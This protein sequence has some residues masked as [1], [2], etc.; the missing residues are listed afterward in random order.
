MITG[1]GLEGRGAN[2]SMITFL[3]GGSTDLPG[4][5]MIFVG[6]DGGGAGG[7]SLTIKV[8]G[9]KGAGACFMKLIQL[10]QNQI[11]LIQ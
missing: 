11:Q 6:Q 3:G 4:I 9:V 7:C 10:K 2:F 8:S 1:C 5:V